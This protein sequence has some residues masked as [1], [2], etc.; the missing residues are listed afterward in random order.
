[1]LRSVRVQDYC[2]IGAKSVLLE[3]AM[4]EPYSILAPGSVLPPA[5]RVPEGELWA[6]SPAR[7]VRKLTEDDRDA[8]R[9]LALKIRGL[10]RSHLREELPHGAAWR[11][12]EH[13]RKQMYDRGL[14]ET[15][16]MRAE[17][18]ALREEQERIMENL[19]QPV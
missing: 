13:Y 4:M 17:K 6:G 15:R 1:M 18:Y 14:Y 10:A 3:G 16:D 9:E 8:I 5:R 11:G 12:V 19:D 2:L 7:F